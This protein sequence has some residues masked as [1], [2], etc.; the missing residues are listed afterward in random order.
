ME[1]LEDYQARMAGADPSKMLGQRVFIAGESCID[2][3]LGQRVFI[4]E[5]ESRLEVLVRDLGTL[6][7]YRE[8]GRGRP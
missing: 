3:M 7:P 1:T 2:I 8:L 5:R 4:V 6:T